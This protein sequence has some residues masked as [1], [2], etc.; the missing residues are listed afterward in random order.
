VEVRS[1]NGDVIVIDAG[2]GIRSLGLRLKEES[3]KQIDMLFTHAH[4]D[5][6]MGFPFFPPIYEKGVHINVHGHPFGVP[7]YKSILKMIMANPYC[8]VDFSDIPASLTFDKVGVRPFKI[9]HFT[10]TPILLSHPNGGIGYRIEEEG[11]SFVFLT[12]NELEY[13]HKN[14]LRKQAYI[15]FSANADLLIH[16]AEYTRDDYNRMWGHSIFISATELG[17]AAKVKRLGLFHHNQRRT[18]DEID[19]IVDAARAV[20]KRKKSKVECFAVSNRFELTL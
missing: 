7:S 8:P 1:A 12:D 16:D 9:G 19:E 3:V 18:D 14:G 11:K 20:I 17:I 10:I 4:L 6:I 13:V 2:T 5:H 15:D